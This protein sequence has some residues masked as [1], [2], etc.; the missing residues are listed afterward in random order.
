MSTVGDATNAADTSIVQNPEI[1]PVGQ[2][3]TPVPPA[4]HELGIGAS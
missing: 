2:A 1:D 3:G 4:H